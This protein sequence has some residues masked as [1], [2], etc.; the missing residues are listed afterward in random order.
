ML[1]PRQAH[2]APRKIINMLSRLIILSLALSI[3]FVGELAASERNPANGFERAASACR[4]IHG[5]TIA[6][7]A[8]LRTTDTAMSVCLR[9]R[10]WWPDGS[11]TL[12]AMLT[13]KTS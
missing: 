1:S 11:Q 7:R 13:N 5:S 12:D 8:K 9:A 2:G 6:R 4:F 3:A 10:G